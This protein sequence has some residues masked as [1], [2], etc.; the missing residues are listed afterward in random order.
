MRIAVAAGLIAIGFTSTPQLLAAEPPSRGRAI[1]EQ[2]TIVADVPYANN[3]NPRQQ[4]DLFL[5][6]QPVLNAPL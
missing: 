4:L 5:P 2:I 6:K 1:R 3:D